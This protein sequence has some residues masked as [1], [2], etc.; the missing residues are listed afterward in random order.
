VCGGPVPC[1]IAD[2]GVMPIVA[3]V[4]PTVS[5]WGLIFLFLGFL[6]V[7]SAWMYRRKEKAAI[8]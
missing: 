4:I 7:G 2:N 6:S 5:E 3:Q 8:A 1:G